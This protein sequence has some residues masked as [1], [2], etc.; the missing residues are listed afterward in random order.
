MTELNANLLSLRVREFD[1]LSERFNLR[2]FPKAAIF[3]R[4]A[5]L[6]DDRGCFDKG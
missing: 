4:D 2:V 5:A 6:W 3:G 1:R